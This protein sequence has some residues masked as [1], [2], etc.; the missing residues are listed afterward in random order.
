[1]NF[2]KFLVD[3]TNIFPI[4]NDTKGGQL[5]SEWNLRT[6]ESVAT[7]ETVKYLIG[8]SYTHSMEDFKVRCLSDSGG[9]QISS[10]VLEILPGRAVINGHFVENLSSIIIDLISANQL[11][12][13]E[14]LI[15]LKGKLCVGLRVY[16]STIQTMSGSMQT[17]DGNLYDGIQVVILPE[18]Q[19]KLPADTPDDPNLL[20]AH[21]KLATFE[22][23]NGAIANIQN[24][25]DKIC[26]FPASRISDFEGI[27][28]SRYITKTGLN[29]KKLYVFSGKGYNPATGLDTWC[30]AEDSLMIWDANPTYTLDK[31]IHQEASF[32][33]NSNDEIE[34]VIPHKQVDG[35]TNTEGTPQY[36]ETQK[37]KFPTADY[38]TS[39]AGIVNRAYTHHIKEIAQKL[40]DYY[41]L[42]AGKQ[43]A[44][45]ATLDSKDK[46][47]SINPKWAVG[48]YILIGQDYTLDIAIDNV[49][50]PSTLYAVLPGIVNA[51]N[52]IGDADSDR[53]DGFEIDKIIRNVDSEELDTTAPN[54][55]DSDVY[56]AY[57]NIPENT[58]RG[59]VNSDYFT[60]SIVS[61]S[62]VHNY[63]YIVSESGAKGY[64]SPI[65]LTGEIPF[66]QE[67]VVGGF[68]NV[69]ETALD[70]GYVIRD[71]SGH[72][73]LMDYALLRMGTYAYQIG[74]DFVT[75]SGLNMQGIQEQL[76]EFV[77]NRIAFPNINHIHV[78]KNPNVINITILVSPETESSEIS[79]ENLDS[80]F[81]T[82]I[83]LH[84]NGELSDN[85]T[86]NVINCEKIRID[87]QIAGNPK[88][89]LYRSSLYYDAS[90][91]NRLHTIQDMSLWYEQFSE[92]DPALAVNGMTVREVNIPVIGDN[93][94][95]WNLQVPNDNHYMYA[96]Q[97]VTFAPNG[98][99][100]GCALYIKNE[101]TTNVQTGQYI[102]TSTFDIPQGT[103]LQYPRNRLTNQL[104]IT[105]SFVTAYSTQDP[106][107]VDDG[108][109][110][111]DTDFTALSQAIDPYVVTN[112]AT[113]VISFYINIS[114]VT[115]IVGLPV[116]TPIDGWDSNGYHVFGG[117]FS[118]ASIG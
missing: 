56:N 1:M 45:F 53:P 117:S 17:D 64:S 66:A 99:I 24:N 88:I 116:G 41:N 91:L 105:G 51:I 49:G 20:T 32:K 107:G 71:D 18:S 46:L 62:S 100:I 10:H 55:T 48:D 39:S 82:S 95:P 79:I 101:T 33:A 31:P 110:V 108:Y 9:A 30:E 112:I 67:E 106:L 69:P 98:D 92:D 61:T 83:Y 6:R 27:I 94:N 38:S 115:N 74:E 102:I 2:K 113:G 35:M 42:P 103:N 73:R 12:Q 40:S 63:Y 60:Y 58:W 28:D 16:Y 72:L 15:P 96:L 80:R 81:G 43:R 54:I 57:W 5:M 8:P 93:L 52:Y 4:A 19:F 68:L 104:K 3:T 78:A 90:I 118:G 50:A 14:N 29:P 7:V 70:G 13:Q 109:M 77:N 34:L 11:A 22:Y 87:N 25:S 26:V 85:T 59:K 114:H 47:P 23:I 75:P 65:L 111:I 86:I 84:I 21:L 44:Y 89:N 97:S 76:N 37:I 36:Y